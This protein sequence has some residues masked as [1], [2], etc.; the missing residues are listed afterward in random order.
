[1][2]FT[3]IMYPGCEWAYICGVGGCQSQLGPSKVSAVCV[4]ACDVGGVHLHLFMFACVHLFSRHRLAPSH[5][6]R[7]RFLCAVMDVATLAY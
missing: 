4:W 2:I 1:M 7:E 6:P 3:L 5:R